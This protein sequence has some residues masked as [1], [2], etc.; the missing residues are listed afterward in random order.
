MKTLLS[1]IGQNLSN[2]N[3]E[4]LVE[5]TFGKSSTLEKDRYMVGKKF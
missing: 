2:E 1:F 3:L 5:E 4:K